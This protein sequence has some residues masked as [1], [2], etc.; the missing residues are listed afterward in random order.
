MKKVLSLILAL[1]MLACCGLAA[2]EGIDYMALVNKLHPLPDGWES[3]LETVKITNSVGDEVEVEAKAYAAYELLKADLQEND[4]IYIELDSARRSVAEQKR[5]MEDFTEKY[6]LDYALKTV[7]PPGYSEHHTGLALDL[8]FRV[9]DEATGELKDVYYN[10]DMEKEEYLPVWDTI[11][12]KLAKYGFIL[13]YLN[14]REY[15]TGYR[16]EPWH[17]RYINDPQTA[18]LI[19]SEDLTLEEHLA[20]KK[21]SEVSILDTGSS[22]IF[23]ADELEDAVS[24]IMCEFA[25]FDGCE[26]EEVRY[27]G[28]ENDNGTRIDWANDMFE[29]PRYMDVA[30]F[31][32][33]FR[34]MTVYEGG[35]DPYRDEF[36][37]EWWMGRLSSGD[38]ETI[39]YGEEY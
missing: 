14:H 22:E 32:V 30:L 17:I 10:E 18:E 21:Q 37:Y 29:D 25:A 4:G 19:M 31:R 28:D 7:A 36:V 39:D 3:S 26:L 9:K 16:Y 34:D 35:V 1:V 12:S 13:R 24:L 2:A 8:Y 11:H 33:K 20:G 23:D 6:G 27:A 15:I 5:I 38:W